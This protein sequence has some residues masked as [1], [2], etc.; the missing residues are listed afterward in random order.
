MP[1]VAQ[2]GIASG[3]QGRLGAAVPGRRFNRATTINHL[4]YPPSSTSVE[5]ET[6]VYDH[7]VG[8][9]NLASAGRAQRTRNITALDWAGEVESDDA[10]LIHHFCS[11][12]NILNLCLKLE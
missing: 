8:F 9:E 3:T 6:E 5:I 1:H 12:K 4:Q 2:R 7:T 11:S 10:A